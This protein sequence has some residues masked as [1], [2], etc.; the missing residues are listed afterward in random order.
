MRLLLDAH[1]SGG[2]IG[3]PLQEDGHDVRA[4]GQE[5]ALEGLGDEAVLELAAAERRILVTFDVVD[6][7]RILREW[8][9]AGRRHAGA[10]LIVGLRHQDYARV[11]RGI[12]QVLGR[13]PAQDDWFDVTVF[14]SPG[15]VS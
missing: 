2:R 1:V 12:E 7:P 5:P 15:G 11:V 4:I 9:G 13:Y 8:A 3:G 14:V 6:F 10:I